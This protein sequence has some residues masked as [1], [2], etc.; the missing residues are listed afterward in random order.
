MK[1]QILWAGLVMI[2]ASCLLGTSCP[3]QYREG[4]H[5]YTDPQ[6]GFRIACPDS[7]WA[8]TDTTGIQEVLV[9]ITSETM[10]KDFIPNVTVSVEPLLAMMTAREYGEKNLQFLKDQGYEMIST[11]M[12]SIHR[13]AF[14]DLQ[15]TQRVAQPALRFRHLCLVKNRLGFIITCTVP[16]EG[17][18]LCESDFQ[19]IVN[20]FRFL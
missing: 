5:L 3:S 4:I 13:N 8:L 16:E 11:G 19:F 6:F 9:I 1:T 10:V 12:K 2:S 7:G 14:Y 15:C 20:S 17:Y 18:S